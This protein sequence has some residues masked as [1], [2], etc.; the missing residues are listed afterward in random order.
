M[1][2]TLAQSHSI[3][4]IE[5][6]DCGDVEA[7][8]A[9][10]AVSDQNL[11]TWTG[12]TDPEVPKNWTP[13][14]KWLTLVLVS[15]FTFMSP[16]SSSVVAPS[17]PAIGQDLHI[18][19]GFQQTIAMSVFI[20]AYAVGPLFFGPLCEIY[21][22]IVVLQTTNAFY[23]V[24]N[25][26]C[27]FAKTK[28]Q[29]IVFRFLS[30]LGGSAPQAIG[31]GVIA[32]LFTPEQRGRALSIYSLMPLFGP[33]L[34]PIV[35]A[36]ITEYTTWRW[37]LYATSIADAII[38][39]V[40][41]AFL[42]ETY[43][44]VLLARKRVRLA[45][46]TGNESLHTA[47]DDPDQTLIKKVQFALSRPFRLL[48]T[49]IIL[50]VLAL[51]L[52]FLVGLTYIFLAS[53]PTLFS[54]PPPDGYGESVGVGGLNYISLALGSFLGA[55]ITAPFQDRI[56]AA[57]KRRHSSAGCPEYSVPMMIP[58]VLLVPIGLFIYGW[59][60]E[61][62][63]HWIV[64]N[65]GVALIALGITI[66]TLCIQTYLVDTYT[67]YAAS[68][69]AAALVLRSLAG[70]GFPLFASSL[71]DR[72]GFGWGNSLL[73]LVSIVIGWPGPVMLWFYGEAL[74]RRSPFAA[75]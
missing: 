2:K 4:S 45:T 8:S 50:Q 16:L 19:T 18:P 71:Y 67:K 11:V 54:S 22:R 48:G 47:F 56:Y 61:Y 63:A 6:E 28:V 68:A 15:S 9:A 57:L 75:G 39:C 51:Y 62:K 20:L 32:D 24:F 55:Q 65:V 23:L 69:M 5:K 53:L 64:P 60:A 37:A 13:G 33:A 49:Q 35:G 31:G 58:G 14:R 25:L 27:G 41:L 12:T 74:R 42:R 17:L 21:G 36:F 66:A 1:K 34:G 40:A 7:S 26:C 3:K 52:M 43:A 30:G 59:T 44:P 70:F 10:E 29:L 73:A 72:L 38:Q 46:S